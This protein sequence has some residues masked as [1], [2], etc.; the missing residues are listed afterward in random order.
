[1]LTSGRSLLSALLSALRS[2]LCSLLSALLCSLL[3]APLS[4]LRRS[5]LVSL[6]SSAAAQ[7]GVPRLAALMRSRSPLM[8]SR[9]LSLRRDSDCHGD[10]HAAYAPR[11]TQPL[12]ATACQRRIS[13][14]QGRTQ[15]CAQ[16]APQDNLSGYLCAR[17]GVLIG[18]L[19][20]RPCSQKGRLRMEQK[21]RLHMEQLVRSSASRADQCAAASSDQCAV[22]SMCS[23]LFSCVPLYEAA[24]ETW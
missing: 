19:V 15:I 21:R 10:A 14:R 7:Q 2:A 18:C 22:A 11:H 23:S 17:D 20:A 1:M 13:V 8:T 12:C 4:A 24:A 16:Q 3:S 9:L 5:S 6:P